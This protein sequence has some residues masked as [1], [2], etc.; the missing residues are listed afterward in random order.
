M[1]KAIISII[2]LINTL[3][4]SAQ[5]Q[6]QNLFDGKTFDG[7]TK[8]GGDT[9]YEIKNGAIIGTT[10]P[11]TPNTFLC[12]EKEYGDFIL[13]LEFKVDKNL[14]SGVQFR[15]IFKDGLVR[16]YQYEIDPSERAWTGGIYDEKR[17]GWICDLDDNPDAQKA[18][19]QGKWNKLRIEARNDIIKTWIN[20]VHAATVIDY[21]TPNGFI[22]LQVHAVKNGET[23]QIAWKNIRI[24]D[25]GLNDSNGDKIDTNLGEWF[26]E[27]NG[28]LAQIWFDKAESSYKVN[29]SDQPWANKEPV[30]ILTADDECKRFSNDEGWTGTLAKN[31][32][33]IQSE[34]FS[35][36]GKRLYRKS[37]TL[38]KE[39]PQNAVV[40]FDG[41]SLDKWG[42]VAPKEWLKTSKDALESV[43]LTDAG[44]IEIVPEKGSIITNDHFGDFTMQ[45][46]FRLLGEKT[47]GGV[48]LQSRYELNIKDSWGQGKGQS[49]GAFGN[50][51]IPEDTDPDFNYALPPMIWQ[52]LDVEFKAPRFDNEG[53]KTSNASISA[54]LNGEQIYVNFEI[55]KLK[56]AAG[57]LGESTEGPI[58]LQEHGTGYQFRNIWLIQK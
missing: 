7:W 27:N 48:Y 16:G 40:L 11:D 25:L 2:A 44:N 23:M 17:R 12:T 46:E 9:T 19:K 53:N 56:G 34:N 33:E 52:T 42:G 6:W 31:T 32:L 55:A 24:Q 41:T 36:T 10:V 13:E 20:G 39:A 51:S 5:P 37:P 47:N 43:I 3:V 22:A 18:F 54:W 38:G 49:T 35:F 8:R 21:M 50:V 14:N 29:L 28:W 4:A 26:D 57:R 58:Y 45:L 15:S 30:T 1:K